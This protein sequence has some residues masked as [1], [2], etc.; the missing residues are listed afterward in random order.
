ML[1]NEFFAEGKTNSK[2]KAKLISNFGGSYF[3]NSH[4][5]LAFSAGHS[6]AGTKRFVAFL[7]YGIAWGP[8]T[9]P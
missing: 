3:F 7:G 9:D 4:S 1:G 6:I 5:F 2:D 8:L